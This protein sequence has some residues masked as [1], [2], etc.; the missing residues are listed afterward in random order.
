MLPAGDCPVSLYYR[1]FPA[2]QH[3]IFTGLTKTIPLF[4]CRPAI[5]FKNCF[6]ENESIQEYL[7]V[8]KSVQGIN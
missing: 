4:L 2:G 6:S 1:P 8:F 7:K 5:F 3:L